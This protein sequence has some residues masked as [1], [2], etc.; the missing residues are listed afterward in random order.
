MRRAA[1]ALVLLTVACTTPATTPP[2]KDPGA[3]PASPTPAGGVSDPAAAYP[4]LAAAAD[5][6]GRAVADAPGQATIA[7]VFASWCS[8]CRTEM[9]ELAALL[10]TRVDRADVRVIGVNFRQHE[11]YDD[12]GDSDAVRAFIAEHAP[13]LRVVPA[14][15][16]LFRA[17][18]SPPKV[19]T[20]Y[21]YDAGGRL[22]GVY[23]RR[24]RALPDAAELGALLDSL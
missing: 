5:L 9:D 18:G 6:D 20:V 7:I 10:A 11:E 21:V 17:L 15:D 24:A 16:A 22:A 23:D 8:H 1:A 2:P 12:R 4:L 19:P 3:P 14:D 13:W